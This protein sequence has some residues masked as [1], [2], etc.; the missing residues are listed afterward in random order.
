MDRTKCSA[1]Y[2]YEKMKCIGISEKTAIKNAD[3]LHLYTMAAGELLWNRGIKLPGY[4]YVIDGLISASITDNKFDSFSVAVYGANSWFG[5]QAVISNLPIYADYVAIYPTELITIPRDIL[6][7]I[8]H[9]EPDFAT[10]MTETIARRAQSTSEM[11]LIMQLANGA[12]RSVMGIYYLAE[13][14]VQTGSHNNERTNDTVT[15]PIA[16]SVMATICGVSRTILSK[17]LQKLASIGMVTVKY[18]QVTVNKYSVWERFA[19]KSREKIIFNKAS[20]IDDLL[21]DLLQSSINIRIHGDTENS[22]YHKSDAAQN[23]YKLLNKAAIEKR[24]MDGGA[25]L[26]RA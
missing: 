19:H 21:G 22:K 2:A 24:Q 16:Q 6:M 20:S 25:N 17:S 3:K 1:E 18:G 8:L 23:C 26:M 12:T 5:E 15:L 11:M 14:F 13:G 9:E 10:H 7:E 4:N